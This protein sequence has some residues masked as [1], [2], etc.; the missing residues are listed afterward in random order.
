MHVVEAPRISAS[1]ADR[2]IVARGVSVCHAEGSS[3]V[4]R[5]PWSP[6]AVAASP[7]L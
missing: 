7:K 4:A 1:S 3:L 6:S 2:R 5:F